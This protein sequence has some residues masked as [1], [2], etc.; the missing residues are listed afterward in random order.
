M[1]ARP[2]YRKESG[3]NEVYDEFRGHFALQPY[4]GPALDQKDEVQE[5]FC[6]LEHPG[7]MRLLFDANVHERT[8]QRLKE[9]VGIL[10][11][12]SFN[13]QSNRLQK[14]AARI[15]KKIPASDLKQMMAS[16]LLRENWSIEESEVIDLDLACQYIAGINTK[17][18]AARFDRNKEGA[19]DTIDKLD[20]LAKRFQK[21]QKQDVDEKFL[22]LLSDWSRFRLHLKYFRFAHRIFNRINVITDAERAHLSRSGG[23]LYQLLGE[24]EVKSAPGAEPRIAHH[25]ILKADVRGSTTVTQELIK[26]ELNPAS[27]FSLRFFGPI[28]ELLEVYGAVKVFIEGDA[29]ILGI[30]EYDNNPLGWYSVSRACGIAKEIL[31]IVSSKNAH[32]RQTGLPL[33]EIGIGICYSDE[34]PLFL[35]DDNKP[36]MISPAIGDADRLSSCSWRL[37]ESF[38]NDTFNVEVLESGDGAGEK[39]QQV[40]RYNVNGIT[41]DEGGFQKLKSE[42]TLRRLSIRTGEINQVMYVGR[43]PDVRGKERELVIREGRVGIWQNEQVV[44]GQSGDKVF[45][46]VLP[47]SKFASQVLEVARRQSVESA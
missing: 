27:Y 8:A 44:A 12:L 5:T 9:Q 11:R 43:F 21:E 38:K 34:S 32:S 2:L 35:F 42:I 1:D 4:L 15:R 31:D 29:V 41:L 19:L 24:E 39:G 20:E 47:N 36:I 23:H 18:V 37:R 7:H 10:D 17:R 14:I 13:R 25:T 3:Q 40:V 16:Y 22:R 33:L 45:Y 6:W 28:T 46:E 26:K 30:Y